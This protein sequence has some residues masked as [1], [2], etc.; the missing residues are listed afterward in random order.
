MTSDVSLE[1]VSMMAMPEAT[2]GNGL[3]AVHGRRRAGTPASSGAPLAPGATSGRAG[4]VVPVDRRAVGHFVMTHEHGFHARPAALFVRT[5]QRFQSDIVLSKGEDAVNGKS[6]LGVLSL[7]V[8]AGDE[9]VVIAD[10]P[11][12]AAAIKSL[13]ALFRSG[14]GDVQAV[15]VAAVSEMKTAAGVWSA[16]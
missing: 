15:A 10:G 12:A 4:A 9:V 5:A 6:I 8:A 3:A 11:D 13:G 7:C 16:F 14:F 2:A 1:A